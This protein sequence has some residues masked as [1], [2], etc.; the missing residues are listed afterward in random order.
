MNRI[1]VKDIVIGQTYYAVCIGSISTI[2]FTAIYIPK[3]SIYNIAREWIWDCYLSDIGIEYENESYVNNLNRV[4]ETEE[5][6]RNWINTER[7]K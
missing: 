7:I 6:A 3:A 2:R 4:F 1:H 5:E